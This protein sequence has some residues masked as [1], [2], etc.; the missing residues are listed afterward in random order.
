M[1]ELRE[2]LNWYYHRIELEQLTGE[3]DERLDQLRSMARH[4]EQAL[5]RLMR[6]TPDAEVASGV[7]TAPAF[8][9]DTIRASL[10]PGTV[11]VEYFYARDQLITAVLSQEVLEVLPLGPR[12][13]VDALAGLLQF[14]L[15]KFRLGADYAGIF[16]GPMLRATRTHL[17]ELH[18]ILIQPVR[19]HLQGKHLV[20]VPHESLHHLPLHALFDGGRYLIDSYAVSYAPSAS[21]YAL[22]RQQPVST[23]KTS[24]VLGVPDARAPHIREESS[25]VAATLPDSELFLGSDASLQVLREKAPASRVVHIATHGRFRADN[26]MFSSIRLGDGYL[27]LYDLNRFRLPVSLVTLSGCSTGLNVVAKG[28]ELLGLV[29]G[30]LHAGA[31]SLLLS[32]WDVH[33]RS[34]MDLMK[35]FYK[36]FRL[37]GDPAAA[38]QGTMQE[39]RE[40]QPHPYFW[41]PFVVV[42]DGKCD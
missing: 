23:S 3:G 8:T 39:V 25:V 12:A 17:R 34:T 36:R 15:S 5:I 30:L 31:R 38:L 13:R 37:G 19:R 27:T 11:L 1:K 4:R 7:N 9:I 35:R 32:L 22:C 42:G 10:G 16:R 18:D 6:D 28:D 29:R 14:Q 33:D 2:D 26:P 41:A 24:L 40:K 20:F 21:I